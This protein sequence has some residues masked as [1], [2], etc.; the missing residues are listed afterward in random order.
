MPGGTP[1][2]SGELVFTSQVSLPNGKGFYGEMG[3]IKEYAPHVEYGH[4]IVQHGKTVGYVKGQRY[5]N[6]NVQI[7]KPIFYK[8]LL[9]NLKKVR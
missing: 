7:Q 3:Y 5:L 4:R 8:S 1:R 6:K 2:D 9:D